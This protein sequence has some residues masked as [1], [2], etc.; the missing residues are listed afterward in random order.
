MEYFKNHRWTAHMEQLIIHGYLQGPDAE[1][2]K[3]EKE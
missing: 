2:K 3:E 1:E